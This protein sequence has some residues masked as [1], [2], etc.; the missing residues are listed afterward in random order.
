[1]TAKLVTGYVDA[2]TSVKFNIKTRASAGTGGTNILTANLT[3]SRTGTAAKSGTLI[4]YG[5]LTAG[6]YLCLDIGTVTGSVG[7]LTA[8]L[9]AEV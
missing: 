7:L 9:V 2:G 6:N 1:M 3:A 8:S 5:T 4:D